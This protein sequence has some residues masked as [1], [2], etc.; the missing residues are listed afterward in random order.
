MEP[1][2]PLPQPNDD[3]RWLA[4]LIRQACL[5]IAKGIERR[6]GL[7]EKGSKAA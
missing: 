4:M 7:N 5:M 2:Q 6:Y 1:R 3:V